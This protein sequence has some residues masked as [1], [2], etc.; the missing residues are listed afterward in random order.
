M[1]AP[2]NKLGW[3][4]AGTG[5]WTQLRY[6]GAV[7]GDNDAFAALDAAQHV[8][9]AIAQ[10]AHRHGRHGSKCITGETNGTVDGR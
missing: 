2:S 1:F 3:T 10:F 8:S 7:T 4:H 9:P 5:K 6:G